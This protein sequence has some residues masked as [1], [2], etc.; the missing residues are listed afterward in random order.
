MIHIADQ[1]KSISKIGLWY[2]GKRNSLSFSPSLFDEMSMGERGEIFTRLI[3][4]GHARIEAEDNVDF[5]MEVATRKLH[6]EGYW[7]LLNSIIDR[8][9]FDNRRFDDR[10]CYSSRGLLYYDNQ[11]NP[12][13]SG[14]S[15]TIFYELLASSQNID[16]FNI[17][18][19]YMKA[20]MNYRKIAYLNKTYF[21]HYP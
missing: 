10:S 5:N 7:K 14:L 9:K 1:E 17:R 18:L 16:R 12:H 11:G 6:H 21:A 2:Y 13:Y 19:R 20:N 3:R 4:I 15:T 8:M